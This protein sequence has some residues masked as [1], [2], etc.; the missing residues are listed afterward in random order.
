MPKKLLLKVFEEVFG[1]SQFII[2]Q[3]SAMALG[4]RKADD[5]RRE[6]KDLRGLARILAKT[7]FFRLTGIKPLTE[8]FNVSTEAM[9]IR[10]EELGLVAW[11][12]S[13]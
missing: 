7:N 5:L 12:N 13:N 11:R 6:A 8:R 1:T 10:L 3:E 4:G 2:T 9:A